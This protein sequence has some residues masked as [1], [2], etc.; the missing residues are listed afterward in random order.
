MAKD[1]IDEVI[2]ITG[3]LFSMIEKSEQVITK[4]IKDNYPVVA[5]IEAIK[6]AVLYREYFETNRV[7]DVVITKKS[8][9]IESPGELIPKKTTGRGNDNIKRNIWIY[10]K[11]ITM[12]DKRIFLNNG[13]GFSRIKNSFNGKNRIKFINS[14]IENSFKVILPGTENRYK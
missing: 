2:I 9:L 11:I 12:D 5:I 14:R 3:S 4:I 7:I 13:R 8:I 10:E 6:N 1:E